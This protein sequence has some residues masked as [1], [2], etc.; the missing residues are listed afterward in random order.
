MGFK[1][2]GSDYLLFR[3]EGL[4]PWGLRAQGAAFR[5]SWPHPY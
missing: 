5:V 3:Y 2:T 4:A 1:S